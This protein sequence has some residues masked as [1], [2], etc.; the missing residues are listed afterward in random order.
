MILVKTLH[1]EAK[2]GLLGGILNVVLAEVAIAAFDLHPGWQTFYAYVIHYF[3]LSAWLRTWPWDDS[4][5]KRRQP[6]D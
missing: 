5:E 1:K 3:I 2:I 4:D 6:N